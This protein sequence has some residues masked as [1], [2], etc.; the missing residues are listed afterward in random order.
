MYTRL[1]SYLFLFS[2]L[3][4]DSL[5]VSGTVHNDSGKEVKKAHVTLRNL[6]DAILFEDKTDRKGKFLLEDIEPNFYYLVVEHEEQG[7]SRVKLNPRKTRNRDLI[8]RLELSN[9]DSMVQCYLFANQNPT[10]FDPALDVEGLEATTKAEQVTLTWKDIR[11]ANSYRLFENGVE[12]SIQKK[13]RLE[14]DVTPGKNNC[15][16]VQAIGDFGLTGQ[17][18]GEVCAS[19]PT[20]APRD[21]TI[22]IWKNILSLKWSP[23]NG[24]KSYI[25]KR[26]GEKVSS[27]MG[28]AFVDADLEFDKD[29]YYTIVAMND[30]DQESESSIE[31]K[32]KTREFVSPPILSSMKDDEKVVLIWNEVDAAKI[33][34]VNRDGEYV[35]SVKTTSFSDPMHPGKTYCYQVTSVDQ[36]EVDSEPSNRH[37]TKVPIKEPSGVIAGG[38]VQSIHIN[39]YSVSGAVYYKIY[40][41]V[42]DDSLKLIEK[43]KSTQHTVR[44]LEYEDKKCYLISGIDQDG[45]EGEHSVAVCAKVKDGPHFLIDKMNLIEASGN[46]AVDYRE[47]GRLQFAVHNDGESP[48]HDVTLSVNALVPDQ[49]L[50]IGE[51]TTID[52]LEP[53]KIKYADIEIQALL[54]IASGD[55][56]LELTANSLEKVSLDVPYPFLV[57]TKEVIP[58]KLIMADFSISNDF[59]THYIPK[60]E[61]VKVIVRIQN[62]GEGLTE[63]ISVNVLESKD[64]LMPKFNGHITHSG[65]NPG[66]Y[67]DIEFPIRSRKDQFWP[68]LELIDY[69]D[70]KVIQ[71]LDLALMKHYRS[72]EELMVQSIGTDEVVPYPDSQGDIDV[73]LGM[74]IAKKNQN[75]MAITMSIE[76]YDDSNYPALQFADWDGIIM[77]QYFQ[78]AFGLSDFQLLPS[79]PWQME[80]GPTLNDLQNTFDPHQ[81][82]LRKRII[83]AERYS[84]IEEMDVFLYYRGYGEWV[85]GKPLLIPKDAKPTREVTKYPLEELVQNLSTLSVLGN[86]RTITVFLDVTYLNLEHST[87]IIWDFPDLTEKICILS[88]TSNGETSQVYPK[89]K[90]S[91]FTYALLGGFS[92]NADDGDQV[93]EL[94]ELAEYVYQFVPKNTSEIPNSRRQNPILTGMDLK[95]TILDLRK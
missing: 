79:K 62:V 46:G 84:G 67:V 27:E 13:N 9:V 43:V 88:A 82:D 34:K 24:A 75:A 32:G 2:I 81:G 41:K 66:E 85:N 55:H 23:V 80:G 4:S 38:D 53:G 58:P 90:H 8:L 6:Q 72:P 69:L 77:R 52:T 5:T 7:F 37:C 86:I 47:K 25:I 30:L 22:E 21:I 78:N 26:D 56:D 73:D 31:V 76:N 68:V 50:V 14:K 83:S 64:Y 40:E 89:K 91:L 54:N 44:N 19:A 70:N 12:I 93:I 61:I 74:P 60:N 87:E 35:S 94:G 42:N 11:Q 15:Y 39:W 17:I 29:Y 65:L 28:P 49:N 33:Y 36:Y 71:T 10:N 3:W 57:K 63:S 1:I 92:G 20:K 16:T 95:R 48:A 45:E 51:K 59:G 18:S